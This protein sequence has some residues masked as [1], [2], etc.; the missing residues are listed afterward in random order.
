VH[1]RRENLLEGDVA[2]HLWRLSGPALWGLFAMTSFSVVDTFYISRLGTAALAAFAFTI[3]VVTFFMGFIWGMMVAT[4]SVLSR[5]YG[6]GDL[7]AVRRLGTD[8]LVMTLLIVLAAAVA[9]VFTID[10][11]FRLMGATEDVMPMIHRF[12]MVWYCGMGFTAVLLIGIACIRAD[13][14]TRLPAMLQ[15]LA[16]VINGWGPF[17]ELRLLGAALTLIISYAVTGGVAFWVLLR[18][19]L[20]CLPLFHAG[21]FASWR[22]LLHVG[23]PSVLSSLIAPISAAVVTAIAAG[24]GHAAVAALGVGTR[25]EGLAL[26]LFFALGQGINIFTGQNFGAGN[27]GRVREMTSFAMRC[28]FWWSAAC[29]GV[30]WAFSDRIPLLF[31]TQPDVVRYTAEYLRYVPVSYLGFGA[32]VVYNTAF[33]AMGKSLQAVTL[34]ILRAFVLCIPLAWVGVKYYGFTGIL[35]SMVLTNILAGLAAHLWNKSATP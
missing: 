21:T 23:V 19:G 32:I 8:S 35:V 15:T 3:P 27:Y 18:R 17:P 16:A 24:L 7:E 28:A 34:N 9:G 12:M 29:T 6:R 11:V 22:T 26:M 2:P 31:D 30:L 4:T 5:A 13:G 10:P 25:I 20:L 1:A 14:D 33:Y